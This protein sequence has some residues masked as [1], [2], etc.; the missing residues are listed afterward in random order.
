MT[1]TLHNSDD[2][3]TREN[4]KDLTTLGNA[5]S[6]QLI[7]KAFSKEEGWMKS[8][9][10]LEIPGVGCLVQV[11]TQQGDNVA[12]ALTFVPGV[13]I[14]GDKVKGRRLV[15]MQTREPPRVQRIIETDPPID[16]TG[17]DGD[18]DTMKDIF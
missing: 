5:D 14:E 16:V 9:K 11:S 18:E 10:A 12:E 17:L 7:C 6:F 2:S 1:K 4:V 13:M 8:T 3:G 15:K